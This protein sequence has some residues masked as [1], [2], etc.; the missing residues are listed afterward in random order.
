M[1]TKNMTVVSPAL[2][3]N[4][5]HTFKVRVASINGYPSQFSEPFSYTTVDIRKYI[6][7]ALHWICTF[8]IS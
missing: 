2:Q 1:E 5:H 3:P 8:L 6:T 4:T 7:L